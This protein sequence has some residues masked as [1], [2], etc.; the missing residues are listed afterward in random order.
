[1]SRLV[2]F[3][4]LKKIVPIPAVLDDKGLLDTFK[5]QGDRLVGPCPLHGGDN[6]N[7]FVVSLSKNLWYC[8]TGC[9]G[10]DIVDLVRR[11]DGKNFQQ[12][13][14]YLQALAGKQLNRLPL[15]PTPPQPFKPFV[16]KVPLDHCIPWLQQ[17]GINPITAARFE[18]GAY[19]GKGF[20]ADSI[21]IR[22]HDVHGHPIGYLARRL[23]PLTIKSYGKYQFPPN[24]P[25]TATLY[26]YHRI[27]R[28]LPDTIVVTECPWGVMRLQQLNI[29]AVALMGIQLSESQYRLFEQVKDIVLMLDGDDAGLKATCRIEM[30]LKRRGKNNIHSI[31]LPVGRDPDDLTD[32][33]LRAVVNPFFSDQPFSHRSVP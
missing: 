29:P 17:K 14:Q 12:T 13:R 25:K 16:R 15:P 24:F 6:P 27:A 30:D 9:N 3:D 19:Y 23:N 26:N 5:R 21:A 28:P 31:C 2:Q 33:E 32:D 10:G 18:V 1:M 20:L 8:F 11:L 4:T 22:L 7:A